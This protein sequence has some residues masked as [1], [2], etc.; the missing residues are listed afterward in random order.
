MTATSSIFIALSLLAS[1][2]IGCSSKPGMTQSGYLSDYSMLEPVT[3]A[4]M[5]YVAPN[6][7]A[8]RA[9]IVE[10]VAVLVEGDV[11]SPEDRRE[12]IQYFHDAMVRAIEK[13]GDSVVESPGSGVARIRVA[14]TDVAGSTWWQKVHP[15]SRLAGAGTGGAA[16]EAEVLDSVTGE[17]VGAVVQ[18]ASGNQFDFTAFS[19]LADIKSAIDKW[20]TILTHRLV[21]LRESAN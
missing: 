2:L 19:T 4:R 8:Y 16:M 10:P 5:V 12:A 1:A 17:M 21:E 7:N 14:L 18:T 13:A 3:E 20:S 15:A 9:F 6:A 11:L